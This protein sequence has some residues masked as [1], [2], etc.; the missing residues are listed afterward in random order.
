MISAY[1]S[2]GECRCPEHCKGAYRQGYVDV[3]VVYPRPTGV[4]SFMTALQLRVRFF[5]ERCEV[6]SV[7]CAPASIRVKLVSH[8]ILLCSCTSTV[9]ANWCGIHAIGHL[10]EAHPRHSLCSRSGLSGCMAPDNAQQQRAASG[11]IPGAP[12][13]TNPTLTSSGRRPDHH[14][15]L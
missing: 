5:A 14:P 8:N 11:S 4:Y 1:T 10:C 15:Y 13:H 12:V 6:F 7:K 2:I 3:D 9:D